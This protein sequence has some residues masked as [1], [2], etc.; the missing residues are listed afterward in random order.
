MR[1][2]SLTLAVMGAIS[3]GLAGTANAANNGKLIFNGTLTNI[4]R[5]GAGHRRERR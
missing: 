2:L 5:C 1:K 3:L 4:L